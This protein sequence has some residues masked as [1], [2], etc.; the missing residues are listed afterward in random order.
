MIEVTQYHLAGAPTER[1]KSF[2]KGCKE[3]KQAEKVWDEFH[4]Y[5]EAGGKAKWVESWF[6]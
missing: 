5:R 6:H 3:V 1:L 4:E 2:S